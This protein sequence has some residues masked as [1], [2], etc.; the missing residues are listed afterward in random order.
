GLERQAAA[1]AGGTL[2]PSGAAPAEPRD[3]VRVV[4]GGLLVSASHG[5]ILR[6]AGSRAQD[7]ERPRPGPR[8]PIREADGRRVAVSGADRPSIQSLPCGSPSPRSRFAP[9]GAAW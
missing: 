3:P 7:V 5:A 1:A 6:P 4:H 2:D 8:E 9:T